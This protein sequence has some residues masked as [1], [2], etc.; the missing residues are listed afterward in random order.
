MTIN[1]IAPFNAENT[2]NG[3]TLALDYSFVPDIDY[4]DYDN[5]FYPNA[6]VL[7]GCY[8]VINENTIVGFAL[9][10]NKASD[11]GPIGPCLGFGDMFN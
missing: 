3:W 6:A 5:S 2:A 11:F 4:N 9:Y 8:D 10:E 1:N 7:A